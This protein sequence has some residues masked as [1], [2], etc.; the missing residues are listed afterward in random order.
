[1]PSSCDAIKR[2]YKSETWHKARLEKILSSKGRCEKCGAPGEEVH[3]IIHLTELNINDTEITLN[4]KDLF[5]LCRECH[6][7]EQGRF[8]KTFSFDEDGNLKPFSL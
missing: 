5:L 4:Q 7:K 8:K 1:M 6:N 3:H 2:F